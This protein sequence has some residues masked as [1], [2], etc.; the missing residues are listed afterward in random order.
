MKLERIKENTSITE[1]GCWEWQK[2]CNSAGYGQLQVDKVY[3]L[4][5]R[6]SYACTNSLE[7]GDVVRH[8]C[9]NTRC[10][11]PEHLEV[12]GHKDNW[13]DSREVHLEAASKR[14]KKWSVNGTEYATIREASEQTGLHQ[15][16]L[17]KH[18]SDGVFNINSY[19]AG[20]KKANV[21]PK[22]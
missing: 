13:A 16:T 3:W 19:R 17:I 20:C 5:H 1:N 15:G 2:S 21:T 18:T 22:L 12:G 10:C 6:Y 8:K 11:N 9:H 14:R 7:K 4:A